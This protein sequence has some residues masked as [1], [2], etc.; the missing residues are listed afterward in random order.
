MSKLIIVQRAL[1]DALKVVESELHIVCDCEYSDAEFDEKLLTDFA[2]SIDIS[3]SQSKSR[4][5]KR[6]M[7]KTNKELVE[8]I[9]VFIAFA[10]MFIC[11]TMIFVAG[12][13]VENISARI[14]GGVVLTIWLFVSA[15]WVVRQIKNKKENK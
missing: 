13:I 2:K 15:M 8:K 12:F 10:L 9:L 1:E 14:V 4:R 5:G 11:A 6:E 3:K 7:L